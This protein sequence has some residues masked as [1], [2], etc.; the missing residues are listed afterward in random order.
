MTKAL[1]LKIALAVLDGRRTAKAAGVPAPYMIR[2]ERAGI[3]QRRGVVMTGRRGRPA[4][5]YSLTSKGRSRARRH[6]QAA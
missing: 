2:A 1:A 3:V 4:V 5:E 6:L